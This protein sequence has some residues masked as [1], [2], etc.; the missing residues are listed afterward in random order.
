MKFSPIVFSL[1]NLPNTKSNTKSPISLNLHHQKN[2]F[3]FSSHKKN[4]PI[5]ESSPQKNDPKIYK[6]IQ[7]HGLR[8]FRARPKMRATQFVKYKIPKYR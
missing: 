8:A 2:P 5:A 7:E 3:F 4:T 6:K 1:L